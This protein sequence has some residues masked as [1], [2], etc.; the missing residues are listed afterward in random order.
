MSAEH[1]QVLYKL[2]TDHKP[3]EENE[4]QRIEA[5]GGSVYRSQIVAK[6]PFNQY[7]D[8]N[9]IWMKIGLFPSKPPKFPDE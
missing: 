5:N 3:D 2:S 7:Y 4:K 9:P 6:P 1:S 8:Y